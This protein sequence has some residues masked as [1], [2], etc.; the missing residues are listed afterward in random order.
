MD[1]SGFPRRATPD[2]VQAAFAA[3][4]LPAPFITPAH[5]PALHQIGVC[6][7]SSREILPAPAY[8]LDTYAAEYLRG[9]V[10][11]G[12][13]LCGID[14]YGLNSWALV[15]YAVTPRAGLFVRIPYEGVYTEQLLAAEDIA[16]HFVQIGNFLTGL[17]RAE[18][19]LMPGERFVLLLDQH[20]TWRYLHVQPGMT[21]AD[22]NAAPWHTDQTSLGTLIDAVLEVYEIAPPPEHS[23]DAA[24]S[25]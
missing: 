25:A 11:D 1:L 13:T 24:S 2:F 8:D 6:L 9:G 10:P 16:L 14:G 15:Y 7:F 18:P 5:Q 12:Y 4:R 20:T 3:A 17:E 21:P 19:L 22:L 23:G